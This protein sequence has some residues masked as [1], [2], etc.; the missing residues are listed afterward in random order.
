[1][2]SLESLLRRAVWRPALFVLLVI[3]LNQ[4]GA[5]ERSIPSFLSLQEAVDIALEGSTQLGS[6]E[7]R[8]K[9][10]RSSK[11]NAWLGLGPN[12]SVSAFK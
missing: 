5:Q 7:A 12:I 4:L 10:T 8:L 1:M 11:T 2:N 9:A 3:P 6:Q